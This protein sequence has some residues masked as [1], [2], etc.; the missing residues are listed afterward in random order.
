M[1]F[2]FGCGKPAPELETWPVRGM[3]VDQSGNP[4]DSG[5]I[6]F[7]TKEDAYLQTVGTIE[8]DGSFTLRTQRRGHQYQG[9]VARTYEVVVH[10]QKT[11]ADGSAYPIQAKLPKPLTVL[12]GE[13][14]FRI[15]I[16]R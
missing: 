3:I 2:S 6:R 10:T 5:A 8:A 13:N 12:A 1:V 9:A 14:E 7:E 16:R 15:E 4:V 11:G